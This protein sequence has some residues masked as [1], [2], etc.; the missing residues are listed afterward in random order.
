M[1]F[2]ELSRE[3]KGIKFMNSKKKSI[4]IISVFTLLCLL[5]TAIMSPV[6]LQASAKYLPNV[7]AA[8][9]KPAYW[10][11]KAVTPN[12]TLV[13]LEEI[14]KVNQDIISGKGTGVWDMSTWSKDTYNGEERNENLKKAAQENAQDC[15]DSGAFYLNGDRLSESEAMEK[16]YSPLIENCIDPDATGSMPTGYAICTTR[17]TLRAF[18]A[19]TPLQDDPEDPDFDYLYLTA[20]AVGEPLIIRGKSADGLYYC[21]DT[22]YLSG[23]VPASDI[24]FCKDRAEWLSAWNFDDEKILVVYDDKITTEDS[25]YTPET[26]NRKLPMGTRLKLADRNDWEGKINNRYAYNNY[27]VW[28]PVRQPDGSFE[29]KLAL[30]SEHCQVSEGYLPLTTANLAKV[31]FNQLGNVYGWG[32]MLSSQDCSGYVRAVYSCFGLNLGRNTSHQ[33]VQPVKK[34]DLKGKT[35]EEKA[36]I[37]KSLPLGAELL[38]NGHAMLYL[39]C[40]GDKLYVISSVSNLVADGIKYRVRGAVINTLDITRPNKKTWLSELHTAEIPYYYADAKDLSKA[41]VKDIPDVTYTGKKQQPV[42][43]VSLNGTALKENVH[44][45]VSY[46]DNINQGAASAVI[47]GMGNYKGTVTKKF[48]IK[49]MGKN[50]TVHLNKNVYTYSGKAIKP[51]VTVTAGTETLAPS[52]YSVTYAAGRKKV[53]S[54]KVT[55]KLKKGYTGTASAVFK[56]IPKGTSIKKIARGRQAFTAMWGRQAKKM[57]SKRI[58]GYQLQYA[59]NKKFTNGRETVTIKK[60]NRTSRKITQLRKKKKY[61]VRVRTFMT[62]GKKKY[63]SAWSKVKTVVTAK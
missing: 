15:I 26:A 50:V 4:K 12:E 21:A 17:T 43:E 31:M 9:S 10:S 33:A 49:A 18:P 44:Y 57:S 36:A 24:A 29:S 41:A 1:G 8:M 60:Y 56:I 40:E 11:D 63:Y 22:S 62:V 46:A 30:I 25:N 28:M 45:T 27:V 19:D 34:F 14:R 51:K 52:L 53:G 55:V 38:F 2:L 39:G 37:I 48:Q 58:T 3:E 54:Y 13:T 7:T 35:D 20:V 47:T 59:T 32:G 42:P 23:W 6:P 5:V 16:I 61:Y